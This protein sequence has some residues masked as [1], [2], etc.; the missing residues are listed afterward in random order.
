MAWAPCFRLISETRPPW[1]TTGAGCLCG[2]SVRRPN[3]SAATTRPE[4]QH[5]L[6]AGPTR[7]GTKAASQ[8]MSR[9]EWVA[10]APK[11][12]ER[13][14]FYGG[15]AIQTASPVIVFPAQREPD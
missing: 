14:T 5:H 2:S 4:T 8:D 3:G 1:P 13:G 15:A 11:T 10:P 12:V 9:T 6:A 7:P